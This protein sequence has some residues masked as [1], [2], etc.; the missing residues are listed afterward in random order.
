MKLKKPECKISGDGS[1]YWYLNNKLHRT[2]GPAVECPNGEKA[3][4]KI[5]EWYKNGKHHRIN[6][7]AIEYADG[8][9]IWLKN[10][11]VHRIDGPAIEYSNGSKEWYLNGEEI[12]PEVL[13]KKGYITEEE[14]FLILL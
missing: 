1:K 14:L 3:W 13:V 12:K 2:N 4:Y 10:G 7:P 9:K 11:K 8:S 5:K 6:G